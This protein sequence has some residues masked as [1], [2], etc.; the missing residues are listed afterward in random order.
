MRAWQLFLMMAAAAQTIYINTTGKSHRIPESSDPS[1][2]SFTSQ[3]VLIQHLHEFEGQ[4]ESH[5][6]NL[7]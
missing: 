4:R 3:E 1:N 2:S 7:S 5:N 6:L